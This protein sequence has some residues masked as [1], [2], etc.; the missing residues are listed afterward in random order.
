MERSYG[1]SLVVV[2]M[3]YLVLWLASRD[4]AKVLVKLT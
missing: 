2:F 3:D 1:D 4:G